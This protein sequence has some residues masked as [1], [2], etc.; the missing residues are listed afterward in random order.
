MPTRAAALPAFAQDAFSGASLPYHL[1]SEEPGIAL[2]LRRARISNVAG[3]TAN[4]SCE[5]AQVGERSPWFISP[6]GYID[7]PLVRG[8]SGGPLLDMQCGVVGVIH[9]YG[10]DATVFTSLAPADRFAAE[11]SPSC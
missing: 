9:G 6:A 8:M 10:C 1:R 7:V 2:N 11:A 3:K 4:G 5:T